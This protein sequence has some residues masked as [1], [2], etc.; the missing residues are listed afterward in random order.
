[1]DKWLSKELVHSKFKDQRLD[2]R[3]RQ[4]ICKIHKNYGKSI[5]EAFNDWGEVKAAYRFLSNDRIDESEILQ[6]HF[7]NTQK[8][9]ISSSGPILLL[10]DT[11]EFSY[12]RKKPEE[13]GFISKKRKLTRVS[14]EIP[15]HI[16]VCGI[17]MHASLAVTQE[18]LP[19][20]L[21]ATKFWTRKVFKNTKQMK[22]HI[23]PTRIPVTEKE[24]I[25]W[26]NNLEDS[27][28]PLKVESRR[29]I[30]ICDR[31]GDMY[32]LFCK[33]NELGSNFIVR[34]C[35]NRY[36]NDTKIAEEIAFGSRTYNHKIA[37]QTSDDELNKIKMTVLVKK[38]TL[39]PP[40]AKEKA[41]PSLPV[42][43]ISAIEDNKP[44]DRDRIRWTLHTNLD[45]T[46]KA[47]ALKVLNWYKMRWKIEEYF[48]ILKSGFQLESSKLR[49]AER[50][51]KIISICCIL[52]WRIFWTTIV[53]RSSKKDASPML[54]FSRLELK[55]ISAF[56]KKDK[57][58]NAFDYIVLLA[59][60]GGYLA[61]KSDPPPG[62]Q[63]IWKGYERLNELCEGAMLEF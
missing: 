51:A 41:Y 26:L 5:P 22:R 19:L 58:I 24:S 18:G 60:L 13:I 27:L 40:K 16:S 7:V 56:F 49:T 57:P 54:I 39:H 6:N 63:V 3:F 8:R 33:A 30:N 25:K 45:V 50:L 21:S 34:A 42:T 37:I 17:L 23:N 20:G 53:A 55:V 28:I 52:A 4:I 46:T 9:I 61:R 38:L 2:S 10:H 36:A 1:M 35:L 59:K 31:E 43:V 47:E 62:N 14:Q 29:V 44:Q 12:K 11:S 32:E 48:K 15:Q